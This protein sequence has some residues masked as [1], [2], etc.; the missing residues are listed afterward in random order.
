MMTT[1]ILCHGSWHQP[2]TWE[3]VVDRLTDAGHTATAVAY[4]GD[5][6]DPTPASLITQQSYVGAV[7]KAIDAAPEPVVLVGHS[8]GGMVISLASDQRPG[9]TAAAVYLCGFLLA[10]GMSIFEYTQTTAEFATSLLPRY[11][12]VDQETH[13]SSI[14]PEG[15]RETFLADASDADFEWAK[16]RLQPDY[17][18][19]SVTPVSF[20]DGF[21][22]VPRFYIE[23][24]DDRALPLPAQRRMHV[25]AGVDGV[26]EVRGSHSAQ[27]TRA[28]AVTEALLGFAI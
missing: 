9:K 4:P 8:M 1:Y 12:V 19:P 17:L 5:A 15:I 23:T 3:R 26:T 28:G 13:V 22:R 10:E 6:G 11:V 24:T 18:L 27:I 25:E 2:S 16:E 20:G 21:T 14:K 7:L